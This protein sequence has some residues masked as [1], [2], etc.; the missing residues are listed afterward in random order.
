MTSTEPLFT[1]PAMRLF[2]CLLVLF[3]LRRR[4]PSVRGVTLPDTQISWGLATKPYRAA[5]VPCPRNPVRACASP[6]IDGILRVWV[7]DT[8]KAWVLEPQ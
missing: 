3:M 1:G 6:L 4:F 7:A 8:S 2:R 5:S